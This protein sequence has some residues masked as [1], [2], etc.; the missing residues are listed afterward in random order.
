MPTGRWPHGSW[1]RAARTAGC[2]CTRR[3][4]RSPPSS[5]PWSAPRE[6]REVRAA[7]Q[8][9]NDR[10][11]V[12]LRRKGDVQDSRAPRAELLPGAREERL[13]LRVRW[14]RSRRKVSR[15]RG[16]PLLAVEDVITEPARERLHDLLAGEQA[17]HLAPRLRRD[18]GRHLQ[19]PLLEGL[20]DH[21]LVHEG[22]QPGGRDLGADPT[23][24]RGDVA[25][26]R[27]DLLDPR[28][29]VCQRTE[30]FVEL[31]LRD[32]RRTDLGRGG[33]ADSTTARQHRGRADDNEKEPK[34]SFHRNRDSTGPHPDQAGA[35]AD[36]WPGPPALAGT[37]S[38]RRVTR[39]SGTASAA[40]DSGMTTSPSSLAVA[41][42]ASRR[43]RTF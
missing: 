22:A 31:V 2:P 42:G 33:I 20:V 9:A 14:L 38:C 5:G 12:L 10:I 37:S 36:A 30:L 25:E 6:R 7:D 17:E 21:G 11:R 26:V 18:L 35:G 16:V 4:R 8:L 1:H 28:L 13:E 27:G 19:A 34:R 43:S 40:T 24:R 39:V 29:V 23:L 3:D 41:R 15:D 32:G